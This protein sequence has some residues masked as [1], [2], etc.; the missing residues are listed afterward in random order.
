TL[1]ILDPESSASEVILLPYGARSWYLRIE[2]ARRSVI[3]ELGIT[4]PDGQFRTLARSNAARIPRGGPSMQAAT[5]SV[6]YEQA[7]AA[8]GDI[9]A[10]EFEPHGA[11]AG[12]P[13]S[14]AGA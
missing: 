10:S 11:A 1:K 12:V 7:W 9:L 5:H 8:T 6:R 3:A 13:A 4:L 2:A 14:A